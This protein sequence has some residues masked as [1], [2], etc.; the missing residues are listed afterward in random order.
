MDKKKFNKKL[1]DV[2]EKGFAPGI[3]DN[4]GGKKYIH[5]QKLSEKE[6]KKLKRVKK[7]MKLGEKLKKKNS[8]Q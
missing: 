7:Y 4:L 3:Y 6:E 8:K 1:Q 2:I 5:G